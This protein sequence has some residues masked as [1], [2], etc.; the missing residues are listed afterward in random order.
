MELNALRRHLTAIARTA[1]TNNF[2][3][4]DHSEG[5]TYTEDFGSPD[6]PNLYKMRIYRNCF[7]PCMGYDKYFE[8]FHILYSND[9]E[10]VFVQTSFYINRNEGFG[11]ELPQKQ[12]KIQRLKGRKN[13]RPN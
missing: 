1:I 10:G 5:Q 2:D 6:I 11:L 4:D 12:F 13:R 8:D 7:E 3:V 9:I